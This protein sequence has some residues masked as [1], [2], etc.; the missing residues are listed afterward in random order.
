MKKTL[1]ILVAIIAICTINI[2]PVKA[3]YKSHYF[4]KTTPGTYT[5]TYYI[6]QTYVPVTFY[7]HA[8]VTAHAEGTTAK[9]TFVC[10]PYYTNTVFSDYT[11]AD[12]SSY[13]CMAP[14]SIYYYTSELYVKYNNEGANSD[15]HWS[16]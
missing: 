13:S 12:V 4:T 3:V 16:Y 1:F 10:Q 8:D 5:E 11:H 15:I 6:P 14:G 7:I 2:S 9:G